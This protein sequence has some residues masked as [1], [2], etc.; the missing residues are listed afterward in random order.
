MQSAKSAPAV[1]TRFCVLNRK[2]KKEAFSFDR[3]V[4]RL[5]RCGD[6]IR[7]GD[8][9]LVAD[10]IVMEGAHDP[11][12]LTQQ[13]LVE[14]AA[15]FQQGSIRTSDIDALL[16][17]LLTNRRQP[18]CLDLAARLVASN[19]Q[20]SVAES[21][22]E[23][24]DRVHRR[25]PSRLSETFVRF[26]RDHRDALDAMVDPAYDYRLTYA[27]LRTMINSY[28]VSLP[29]P[30][31]GS[32]VGYADAVLQPQHN[33]I[34]ME[35]PQFCFMRV[36]AAIACWFLDPSRAPAAALSSAYLAHEGP[37]TDARDAQ[38][39]EE[40]TPA[41]RSRVALAFARRLYGALARGE[42]TFGSPF[43]FNAGTAKAR[44]ASCFLMAP[45]DSIESIFSTHS[46]MAVAMAGGGGIG[47]HM[48]ALR[49]LGAPIVATGGESSGI[50]AWMR[51]IASTRE[52]V[53]QGGRRAGAVALFLPFY[54]PDIVDFL[55]LCRDS[56]QFSATH[57]HTPHIKI[58]V[59]ATAWFF[60]QFDADAD[61]ACV[62]PAEFPQLETISD[63][64]EWQREFLRAQKVLRARHSDDPASVRVIRARDLAREIFETV[65]QKGFPYMFF[66]DNTNAQCSLAR[67][68]RINGSNLC[69][70][71]TIPTVP[72]REDGVCV[73]GTVLTPAHL[74]R[75]PAGVGV[76]YAALAAS[77]GL[78]ATA[79]DMA[80]DL[81]YFSPLM[82]PSAESLRLH[83]TIGVGQAGLVGAMHE[84]G[85]PFESAAAVRE[86]ELTALAVYVGAAEA[87]ARIAGLCG[88]HPSFSTHDSPASRG[89]LQPDVSASLGFLAPDWAETMHA[90][91]PGFGLPARL[92]ALRAALRE[93][94]IRNAY[95]TS[96]QPTA[97]NSIIHGVTPGADVPN[98]MA[99]SLKTS[100]GTFYTY[101]LA[102]RDRAVREGYDPEEVLEAVFQNNGSLKGLGLPGEWEE[103]FK[104]AF[105][106]SPVAVVVHAAARQPFCSQAQ[107]TNLNMQRAEFAEVMTLYK[108]AQSTGL[109]TVYYVYGATETSAL[110]VAEAPRVFARA[111]AAE[112]AAASAAEPAHCM[113]MQCEPAAAPVCRRDDPMCESCQG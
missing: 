43:F 59:A 13:V 60:A 48:G 98:A 97:S 16:I 90:A 74:R 47:M 94:G 56:S 2:G 40:D 44:M 70:E 113:T 64:E 33:G 20:H 99:G 112:P 30:R 85:L 73:L 81:M 5:S 89:L 83:R 31:E 4:E 95:L 17:G 8:G 88:A 110:R 26:V 29:A 38:W 79:L 71:I 52:S 66:S 14:N 86:S 80:I 58:G 57:S 7:S 69:C 46:R 37:G 111:P 82:T 102:L 103:L 34:L 101:S 22:S 87:S 12:L 54:H 6:V 78:L 53:N 24:V 84:V 41:G 77:A 28:L 51:I 35:T 3:I 9:A 100:A 63:C 93:T 23:A 72:D 19:L 108:L 92:A 75:G 76:D 49:E 104:G 25:A 109:N 18:G 50:A 27:G 15:A 67:H 65:R 45:S 10:E 11:C 1:R 32:S 68:A 21:F 91:M 107:S 55:C 36:A 106:V 42:V 61:F 39:K 96:T 62:P 105:E